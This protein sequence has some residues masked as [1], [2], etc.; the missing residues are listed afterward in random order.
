MVLMPALQKTRGFSDMLLNSV[1]GITV[2]WLKYA[3]K[4]WPQIC[5][6]KERSILIAFSA[7]WG[8]SSIQHQN[9]ISNFV[10]KISGNV[11]SEAVFVNLCALLKFFSLSCTLIPL[12]M[13]NFSN[14]LL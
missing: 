7:N 12:A 9:S 3:E 5:D 11:Q 10:S 13:Y 1:W 6:W 2:F 14:I 8:Y 4:I